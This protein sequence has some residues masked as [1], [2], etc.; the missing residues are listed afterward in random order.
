MTQNALSRTYYYQ[1]E[2]LAPTDFIRE[3]QYVRDV[4]AVQNQGLYTPGVVTG[5]EL[6][7]S[8]SQLTVSLGLAFNGNGTPIFLAAN[9]MRDLASSNLAAGSTYYVCILY[10]DNNSQTNSQQLQANKTIVEQPI[11][12]VSVPTTAPVP[13]SPSVVL[14]EVTVAAGGVITGQ[15][16][17]TARQTA[18]LLLTP[19]APA[20]APAGG[21]THTEALAVAPAEQPAAISGAQ[22]V[23][24][25]TV[26]P[27]LSGPGATGPAALSVG[28]D[29][30][31]NGS[32]GAAAGFGFVNGA[33]QGGVISLGMPNPGGGY[34]LINL[35]FNGQRVW[36]VD[37]TGTAFSVSDAAVKADIEPLTGA[38]QIVRGLAG[39]TY[40]PAGGHVRRAGLVAQSVAAVLPEAVHTDDQGL[41][42]VSYNAVIAV[43]VEAV[44]SLSDRV[45]AL[46]AAAGPKGKS[47]SPP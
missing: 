6:S 46:E 13:T 37:Q 24:Q 41:H 19:F 11:L 4:L 16:S 28:V 5:M 25:L 14:G 23:T 32:T 45:E 31:A 38:L 22:T 33:S 18:Q 3:Q 36:S 7:A 47:K 26:G 2:L 39:V 42:A 30:A 40:L 15:P 12:Q 34:A 44:K 17:T 10:G 8:G 35:T 43:L 9:L 27:T 29:F 21:G 1:G 20:P